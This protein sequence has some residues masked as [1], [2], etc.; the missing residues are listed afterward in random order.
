[1]LPWYPADYLAGTR[2]LTLAERGAYTDLLF[3]SWNSGDPLP[4][5]PARLA[6]LVG[7]TP[8]EFSKVWPAIADKFID[9]PEGYTNERLELERANAVELRRTAAEKG[10]LGAAKRWHRQDSSAM[11][12]PSSGHSPGINQLM[13]GDSNPSPSLNAIANS[14]DRSV[15]GSVITPNHSSGPAR[16]LRLAAPELRA[17]ESR[18][19]ID[20]TDP[21]I[22]ERRKQAERLLAKAKQ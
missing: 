6:R 9:G 12:Q 18:N 16:P 15:A 3:V 22:Q 4:K 21:K 17:S 8:R 5:D 20:E 10:K 19:G 1:M 2:H 14:D 11:P 13:P 7:V